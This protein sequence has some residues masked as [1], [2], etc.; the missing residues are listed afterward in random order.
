MTHTHLLHS[1]DSWLAGK[2]LCGAAPEGAQRLEYNHKASILGQV[3]DGT[4]PHCRALW[5]EGEDERREDDAF[6]A[7]Y[8][9]LRRLVSDRLTQASYKTDLDL[10]ESNSAILLNELAEL[11][12]IPPRALELEDDLTIRLAKSL[13]PADQWARVNSLL[14]GNEGVI[15]DAYGDWARGRIENLRHVIWGKAREVCHGQ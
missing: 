9:E 7:K 8:K 1:P 3:P 10:L 15:K 12:G 11:M 14:D 5:I 2:T 6:E 4:C 13:V